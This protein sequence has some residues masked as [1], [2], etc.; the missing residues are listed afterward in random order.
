MSHDRI[1]MEANF[2]TLPNEILRMESLSIEA[3]GMLALIASMASDWVFYRAQMMKLTGCGTKKYYRI[4]DELKAAGILHIEEGRGDGGTFSGRTWHINLS[5]CSQKEDTVEAPCTPKPY[6]VNADVGEK[7]THKKNNL[8]KNNN[9]KGD[10]EE[11]WNAYPKRNGQRLGKKPSMAQYL[12]ALRKTTHAEI[13][14]GVRS[15]AAHAGNYA[16]DPMRW[17]RDEGWADEKPEAA[18]SINDQIK[19]WAEKLNS[20]ENLFGLK[21]PNEIATQLIA[22]SLVSAERIAE[23]ME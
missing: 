5:P 9:N 13:M 14:A 17:L 12:K 7:G 19:K 2:T 15:Y 3:R 21:P 1:K 10:F 11:F 8:N 6:T 16:K 18:T 20:G 4:L 23:V 22:Q